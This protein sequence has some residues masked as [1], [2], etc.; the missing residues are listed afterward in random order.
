MDMDPRDAWKY[1]IYNNYTF[2]KRGKRVYS[3]FEVVVNIKNFLEQL[4]F[5]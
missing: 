2:N 5:L 4:E 3:Y 1:C